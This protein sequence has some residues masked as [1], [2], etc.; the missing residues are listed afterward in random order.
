[1]TRNAAI[2]LVSSYPRLVEQRAL[3]KA[4]ILLAPGVVIVFPGGGR[5]E[6]L[7]DQVAA[8]QMR[9]RRV[10]KAFEDFDV[11]DA[12]DSTIVYVRGTLEGEDLSGLPFDG[13]RFVDRFE[14]HSGLITRH[15]VWNDIA[16][17]LPIRAAKRPPD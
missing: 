17:S 15:E 4:T 9:F 12:G 8:S 7:Q 1:M 3:D 2:E 10:Q 11:L 13:V 14:I 16:E 6:R 5:F